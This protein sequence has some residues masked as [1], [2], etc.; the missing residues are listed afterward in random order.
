MMYDALDPSFGVERRWLDR[1]V[2]DDPGGSGAS[3]TDDR[4]DQELLAHPEERIAALD[5]RRA[6][7]TG[8]DAP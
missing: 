5:R 2:W 6:T 4:S 8:D 1:H 3:V 7:Y